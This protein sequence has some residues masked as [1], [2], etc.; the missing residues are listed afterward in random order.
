MLRELKFKE[1]KK[2]NTLNSLRVII[3][4]EVIKSMYEGGRVSERKGRL[5]E[6]PEKCE[7][8]GETHL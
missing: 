6:V 3:T 5:E 8:L 2:T 7:T 1:K 4:W